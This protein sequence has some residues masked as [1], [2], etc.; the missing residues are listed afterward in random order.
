LF[1][2]AYY[3]K[4]GSTN[5]AFVDRNNPFYLEG[6]K[7]WFV[8]YTKSRQEKKDYKQ[9]DAVEIIDGLLKV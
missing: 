3:R 9:G 8:F 4:G 2:I 1:R 7:H 6:M 5:A